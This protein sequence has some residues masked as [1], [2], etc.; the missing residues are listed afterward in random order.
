M[1]RGGGATRQVFV[2]FDYG[3]LQEGQLVVV[4]VYLNGREVTG[5]RL[6]EEWTLGS[7]GQAALPLTPSSGFTLSPGD[8]RV[9][10]YVDSHLVQQSG[11]TI[12]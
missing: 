10:V 12:E 3:G 1:A 7:Q 8:Y 11:F 4:K 2:R 9:E 5:L 6:V